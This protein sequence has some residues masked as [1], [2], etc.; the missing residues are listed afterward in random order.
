MTR[1]DLERLFRY[2]KEAGKLYW[3]IGRQGAARGS[4]VRTKRKDGYIKVCIDYKSY[5]VHRLIWIL[6][7]G[8]WPEKEIDHINRNPSDNR[9]ENLREATK[10]ENMMNRPAQRNNTSGHKGVIY[11]INRGLWRAE[12]QGRF[13][14]RFSTVL[15]AR[16]A[17][18]NA[19]EELR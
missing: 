14:G 6:E 2:D 7:T 12:K 5:L 4:E 1:E 13:L 17:Y 19:P 16:A 8:S 3:K 10:S 15:E 18:N 11:D 9:F